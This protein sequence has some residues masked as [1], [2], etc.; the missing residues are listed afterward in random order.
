MVHLIILAR[1][2]RAGLADRLGLIMKK[3]SSLAVLTVL[4]VAGFASVRAAAAEEGGIALA[5]VYDTS[6]SMRDPVTDQAGGT[7]PKFM[8][9][10]RALMAVAKQIQAFAT[11]TSAG[12]RKIDAG[13]FVFQGEGVREAVK[14]GPFDAAALEDF[15][16]H[17]RNPNGNT[18]LGNALASAAR[19]VFNSPFPRKH[20]LI[21]T[22][23]LNTAGPKPEAVLPRLQKQAAGKQ[24]TLSVHF[25]AFDVDA[26]QF[27]LLKQQGATVV[28]AANEQQL[29]SQL[30][31]ILQRKI[32]LEAEEPKKP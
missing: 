5:I 11:N 8:V 4:A 3:I 12:P 31:F 24:V 10:N 22:D 7:T 14:F 32:L 15:A 1:Y 28:G 19:T 18:P 16:R 27:E 13:L 20:V 17:F 23:G 30:D 6:G 25:V 29:N 26:K 2:L 9:A 21:I